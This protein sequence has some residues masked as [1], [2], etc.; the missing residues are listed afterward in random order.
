MPE[1][2]PHH[3]TTPKQKYLVFG[4][5]AVAILVLAG[6]LFL[7]LGHSR[8]NFT[9][10][11]QTVEAKS[12]LTAA[13]TPVNDDIPAAFIEK[14]VEVEQTFQVETKPVQ[15]PTETPTFTGKARGKIKIIN[16]N[17]KVQP[18]MAT[19]RFK[20]PDGL[21]F[22]IQ[23]RINVPASGNV[24]ALIVADEAGE[25]GTLK[26]DTHFTIPGLW[27]GLQDK[28][29]GIATEDFYGE[30][31]KT[32]NSDLPGLAAT[33]LANAEDVLKKAAIEKALADL[34]KLLPSGRKLF[35]DMIYA[36]VTKRE[37][38]KIGDQKASY[39]LKL[40][41]K[42]IG[43]AVDEA[44]VLEAAQKILDSTITK[45]LQLL[46]ISS[47]DLK[48]TVNSYDSAKARAD[49][50][51]TATGKTTLAPSHILLKPESYTGKD[52][53]D[54]RTLLA[55]YPAVSNVLIELSPFWNKK[56]TSD[57]NNLQLEIQRAN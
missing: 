53:A 51:I 30:E 2:H 52:Q 43:I 10:T 19:T 17:S 34:Q 29:Y 36:G 26:K 11:P 9:W 7:A 54:V 35:P 32:Q 5:L 42:T 14:T 44:K 3:T 33:E 25:K 37:G 48:F 12:T 55:T 18:L 40:T 23:E 20:S 45:D 38:P 46:T 24:T 28:I 27:P 16:N 21:I 1:H 22:R 49:F 15:K 6:V 50:E 31:T 4:F 39:N 13:A 56:I 47:S 57:K 8:V 41:V